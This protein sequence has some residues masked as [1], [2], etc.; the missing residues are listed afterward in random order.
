MEEHRQAGALGWPRGRVPSLSAAVAAAG[1]AGRSWTV[2]GGDG[3]SFNK[4]SGWL[5][6]SSAG[7][8]RAVTLGKAA[9]LVAVIESF[10]CVLF[11]LMMSETKRWMLEEL[12]G[13]RGTR[14]IPS[15]LFP[16]ISFGTGTSWPTLALMEG[17]FKDWERR[18]LLFG[19]SKK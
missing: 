15:E 13:G 2:A 18:F 19:L 4:E 10:S 9:L 5:G 1:G 17:D 12:F 3:A 11:S 7:I 8:Y 16:P 6:R 14:S